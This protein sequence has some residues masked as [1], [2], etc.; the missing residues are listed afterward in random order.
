M[1]RGE[2]RKRGRGRDEMKRVRKDEK[3]GTER[4][5]ERSGEEK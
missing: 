2:K 3:R 1:R 5:K 4:G